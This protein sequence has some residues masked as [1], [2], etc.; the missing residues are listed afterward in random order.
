MPNK[1]LY[2][3]EVELTEKWLTIKENINFL[4]K[5]ASLKIPS[6]IQIDKILSINPTDFNTMS[7]DCS[8]G[9]NMKVGFSLIYAEKKWDLIVID[10]A[11]SHIDVNTQNTILEKL[12]DLSVKTNCIVIFIHH[13]NIIESFNDKITTLNLRKDGLY[14]ENRI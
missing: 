1:I 14:A 11:F 2:I 12:I 5:I 6:D 10:E 13:D 7:I 8:T 4:C 3:P 9:T